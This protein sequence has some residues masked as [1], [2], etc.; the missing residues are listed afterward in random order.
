MIKD[1]T[2]IFWG[3][4][5]NLCAKESYSLSDVSDTDEDQP[6]FWHASR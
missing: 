3:Y 5:Q 4:T 2:Q 1:Y 6:G